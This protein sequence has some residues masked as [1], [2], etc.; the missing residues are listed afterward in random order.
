MNS[1]GGS[2]D[3]EI[4]AD[5][6]YCSVIDPIANCVGVCYISSGIELL[7][8]GRSVRVVIVARI[9]CIQRVATVVD[10]VAVVIFC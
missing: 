8:D 10:F 2:I 3:P 5:R 6:D 1:G 4:R 7:Q 9:R